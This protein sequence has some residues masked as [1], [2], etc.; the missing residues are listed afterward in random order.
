MR[1]SVMLA[2]LAKPFGAMDHVNVVHQKLS[3]EWHE[4][5]ADCVE[6]PCDGR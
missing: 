4:T 2:A 6:A 5:N 3:G 1:V